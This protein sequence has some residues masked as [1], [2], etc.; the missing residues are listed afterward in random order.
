METIIF[1]QIG[2]LT[3]ARRN[4]HLM[5]HI[6]D[7]TISDLF[8]DSFTTDS[9]RFRVAH[10]SWNVFMG[11]ICRD[12]IRKSEISLESLKS[13][14]NY[15]GLLPILKELACPVRRLVADFVKTEGHLWFDDVP[16]EA[17]KRLYEEILSFINNTWVD[18]LNHI[19][20][21]GVHWILGP[22]LNCE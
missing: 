14:Y 18:S 9:D 13:R 16:T 2:A 6:C 11:G 17:E 21:T 10:G 5:P 19:I 12:G 22:T 15:E 4:A 1:K 20:R 8:G 3:V 7:I